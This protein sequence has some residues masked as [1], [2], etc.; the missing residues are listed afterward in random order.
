[1][2][3][4]GIAI[5][6]RSIRY[7]LLSFR[8]SDGK[9]LN[10]RTN[11]RIGGREKKTVKS[12]KMFCSRA[13]N[14]ILGLIDCSHRPMEQILLKKIGQGERTKKCSDEKHSK[15]STHSNFKAWKNFENYNLF[16]QNNIERAQFMR[17][18][19]CDFFHFVWLRLDAFAWRDDRFFSFFDASTAWKTHVRWKLFTK[20]CRNIVEREKKI[21]WTQNLKLRTAFGRTK[22]KRKK[23]FCACKFYYEIIE[24]QLNLW[25]PN[26]QLNSNFRLIRWATRA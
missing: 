7:H 24:A 18:T 19:C 10:F 13:V 14:L 4:N 17:S 8:W 2:H 21:E 6:L 20:C 25:T 26:A 11:H 22:R 1:M 9:I 23:S 12:A 16:A 5:I 3:S 15:W